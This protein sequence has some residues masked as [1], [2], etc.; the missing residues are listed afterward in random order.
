MCNCL[1]RALGWKANR[2]VFVFHLTNKQKRHVLFTFKKKSIK[3]N[4]ALAFGAKLTSRFSYEKN[5]VHYFQIFV[6]SWLF[7]FFLQHPRISFMPFFVFIVFSQAINDKFLVSILVLRILLYLCLYLYLCYKPLDLKGKV[8][9][10]KFIILRNTF[11][12]EKESSFT[13]VSLYL[14]SY[15][16]LCLSFHISPLVLIIKDEFPWERMPNEW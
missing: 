6:L 10:N 3:G 9:R 16:P 14:L 5:H 12:Q 2:H 8:K 1:F 15:F 13:Q 4:S 7:N 11:I